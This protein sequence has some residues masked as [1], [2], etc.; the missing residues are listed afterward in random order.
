[1]DDLDGDY[2]IGQGEIKTGGL[3][4]RGIRYGTNDNGG[5]KWQHRRRRVCRKLAAS[6]IR[7]NRSVGRIASGYA[8]HLPSHGVVRRVANGGG[9][10]R[11]VTDFQAARS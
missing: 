5:R 10:V 7:R 6:C 9:V 4:G 3:S 11:L 2:R 8:I 1:I